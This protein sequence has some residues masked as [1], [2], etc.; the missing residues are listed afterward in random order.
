MKKALLAAATA[1][2]AVTAGVAGVLAS[3]AGAATNL[4]VTLVAAGT[5]WSAVYNSAGDPVLTVGTAST[6]GAATY[7]EMAV[8]GPSTTPPSSAPTFATSNYGGGSPHWLIQFAD[9]DSLEGF[10]SQAGLGTSNWTVVPASTGTCSTLTHTPADDTYTNV[11]AFIVNSGCA[12]NVTA[13]EIIATTGQASG[14][15]DTITNVSYNGETLGANTDVVTVANPGTQTSTAGTA[16]TTLQL[17]AVSSLGDSITSYSATG[18]PAGLTLNTTTGAITGTPTTAGTLSVTVT[19]TDSGGVQGSAAF[20]WTVNAASSTT[21]SGTTYTG[22]LRLVKM[23]YCLDDR[24]NSS[25]SGAVVQIWRCNGLQNQV[26]QVN[27]NGTI[28][29]N[30]LCLDAL[31]SGTSNGTRLDLA[32]CSGGDNQ[33]WSTSGW[34]IHYDNPNSSGKVVDDTAWGKSGTQ[35]E[36]WTNNGGGNQVWGTF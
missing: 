2:V 35:Q 3:N 6:T 25:T 18:L 31:N 13:A 26:W 36:L 23:G 24:F 12:G 17:S 10:P 7:A 4:S 30:G 19:A 9:G 34:R 15:S 11:L 33:L 21:P 32:T 16:I 22:N 5:G 28:E 1:A 20:S 29:H 27:S 8:N 14:T